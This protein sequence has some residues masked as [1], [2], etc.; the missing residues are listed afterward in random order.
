MKKLSA[1]F[2]VA[3]ILLTFASCK[4]GE[5]TQRD[6]PEEAKEIASEISELA[7][8]KDTS[9]IEN[10]NEEQEKY[11]DDL[12]KS[13]GDEKLV[14]YIDSDK[15]TLFY[16]CEFKDGVVSKVVSHHVIKDDNYFKVIS[17]GIGADSDGVVD[18]ENKTI[19]GDK[20]EEHKGKT[21]NEMKA[22]LKNYTMLT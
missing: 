12:G 15:Y 6:I 17:A 18:E 19:T 1:L 20:T 11:I 4:I 16:T 7:T 13:E 8:R 2:L 22:F 21:I 9:V 3:A 5:D 14:A 10:I